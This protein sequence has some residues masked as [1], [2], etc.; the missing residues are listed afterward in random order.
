MALNQVLNLFGPHLTHLKSGF[1]RSH[2]AGFLRYSTWHLTR[3]CYL[4]AFRILNTLDH[5]FLNHLEFGSTEI[6]PTGPAWGG[7][8]LR[9]RVAWR[10]GLKDACRLVCSRPSISGKKKWPE[11]NR[12]ITSF[13]CPLLFRIV[14][15]STLRKQAYD[16]DCLG[17]LLCLTPRT[18]WPQT[19]LD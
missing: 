6:Y 7:G 9:F 12:V 11:T 13:S 10:R 14:P 1:Q 19:I 5:C 16:D 17:Y 8:G 2:T 3:P 4:L 15:G 18:C